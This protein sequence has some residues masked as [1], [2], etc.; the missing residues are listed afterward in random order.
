MPSEMP[1]TNCPA[2]SSTIPR[3][4][5]PASGAV[6]EGDRAQPTTRDDRR[7][8]AEPVA[9]PARG[10]GTDDRADATERVGHTEPE[11]TQAERLQHEEHVDGGQQPLEDE[12]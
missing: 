12:P 1:S 6:R 11:R 5:S 8:D 4:S 3:A 7:P 2:H 10:G 9:G